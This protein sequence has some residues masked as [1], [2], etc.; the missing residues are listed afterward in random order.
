MKLHRVLPAGLGAASLALAIAL[1]ALSA[2]ATQGAPVIHEK[3]TVLACPAKP[4]TTVQLEGCAEHRV[5]AA[6][7]RVDTL[8]ARV[9]AKLGHSARATFGRAHADWVA[10]RDA[11]C[12]AQASIY[13]GGSL[14]PV[15]YASCLASIDGSHVSELRRMLT[16]ISPAG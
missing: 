3:F 6:D 13:S 16:S 11:A 2:A 9:F 15:V 4:R 7:R 5:I 8:N 10:Y 1:P 14:Q 12:V